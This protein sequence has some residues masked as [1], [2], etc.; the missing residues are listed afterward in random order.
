MDVQRDEVNITT[1]RGAFMIDKDTGYIKLDQFTETS[2]REIGDALAE[3]L[4]ARG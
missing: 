3:A 1:V 2:D 4:G